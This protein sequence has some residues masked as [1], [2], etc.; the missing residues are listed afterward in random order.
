[1]AS[2]QRPVIGCTISGILTSRYFSIM[3]TSVRFLFFE[4]PALTHALLRHRLHNLWYPDW[5]VPNYKAGLS[6]S[7]FLGKRPGKGEG[8]AKGE[9]RS[10]RYKMP[11]RK[12]NGLFPRRGGK[13]AGLLGVVCVANWCH[14]GAAGIT[15]LTWATLHTSASSAACRPLLLGNEPVPFCFSIVRLLLLFSFSLVVLLSWPLA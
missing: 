6:A 11:K 14:G 10:R 1:M 4:H 5:Q 9:E 2:V 7:S 12:V 13:Q 15:V 8:E 3:L